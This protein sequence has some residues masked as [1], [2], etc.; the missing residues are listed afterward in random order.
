MSIIVAFDPG[1]TTGYVIQEIARPNNILAV[2]QAK[3]EGVVDFLSELEAAPDREVKAIVYEDYRLFASKA[4]QQ[5][6]S[7]FEAVQVIGLIRG[8]AIRNGIPFIRQS[9]DNRD[10]GYAWAQI[11]KAGNHSQ[12]HSRDAMAHAAFYLIK[13]KLMDPERPPR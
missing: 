7:R 5:I 12:S 4:T 11:T 8:F 2:G 3:F 9:T 13:N 6:N 10:R 1:D